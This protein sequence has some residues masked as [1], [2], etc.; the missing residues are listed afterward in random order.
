MRLTGL[1]FSLLFSLLISAAAIAGPA[2]VPE[3]PPADNLQQQ[4][5]EAQA[6]NKPLVLLFSLP[7]C[8]YCKVVRQ[9]YLWPMLRESTAADRPV[10]RELMMTGR[11]PIRDFDGS[12][13]TPAALAKRYDVQVSP[14]LVFVD[15][16][17]EML[18]DP[19]VGGDSHF[20]LA[21]LDR[22]FEQSRKKL[23]SRQ[24]RR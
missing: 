21:Y 9:N 13:T 2:H 10:I 19:L 4:A 1:L 18:S 3:L 15:A 16:T 11:Q 17:G 6:A 5:S 14:T 12:P 20:Y 22:A 7:D 23:N 8:A 24:P